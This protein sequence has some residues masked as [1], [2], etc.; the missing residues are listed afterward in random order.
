MLSAIILAAGESRRMGEIKQLLPLGENTVLEQVIDNFLNSKVDEI[1]LVLGYRA[2]EIIQ[3]VSRPIKIAVNP[4]FKQ[5]L[6]SSLKCGLRQVS[7]KAEA[8]LIALGD[9]PFIKKEVINALIE[10]HNKSNLGI[11]VPV[12]KGKEEIIG[13]PVIFDIKYKA[14]LARLKGD[15]GGRQV[16]RKHPDEVLK[17]EIDSDSVIRDIDTKS[18]YQIYL[19]S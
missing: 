13:H 12:Y 1:I 17:V 2:D 7:P 16:I 4:E 6:S 15:V 18:D 11:T 3:K 5:G 9:Q 19:R 10:T 8:I 14:E